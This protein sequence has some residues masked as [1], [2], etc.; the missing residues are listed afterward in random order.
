M[1][2]GGRIPTMQFVWKAVFVVLILVKGGPLEDIC[3]VAFA[4]PVI[5]PCFW[6]V[7]TSDIS[8]VSTSVLKEIFY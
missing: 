7:L 3:D 2:V 1:A 5:F 4:L 6:M 8:E